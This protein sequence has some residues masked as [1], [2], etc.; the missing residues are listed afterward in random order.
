MLQV[1]EDGQKMLGNSI[2]YVKLTGFQDDKEFF[3]LTLLPFLPFDNDWGSSDASRLLPI[4]LSDTVGSMRSGEKAW[5]T[6]QGFSSLQNDFED[7]SRNLLIKA[8]TSV[9][10]L[11]EIEEVEQIFD[12]FILSFEEKIDAS[13]VLLEQGKNFLERG[14]PDAAYYKFFR[15]DEYL[16][17]AKDLLKHVPEELS[18]SADLLLCEALFSIACLYGKTENVNLDCALSRCNQAETL[19]ATSTALESV[20]A[21]VYYQRGLLRMEQKE[22]EL[23][24]KDFQKVIPTVFNS[25]YKERS[26]LALDA[27]KM[28]EKA[29]Q[30]KIQQKKNYP[31]RYFPPK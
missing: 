2:A 30:G 18:I 3:P 15:V 8:G 25:E 5:V 1:F 29:E 6:L 9:K 16:C 27:K 26:K 23:A 4:S 28:L 20:V 10:F 22:F 7:K 14:C 31:L 13:R 17:E 21:K 12:P 11:V 24:M 19:A